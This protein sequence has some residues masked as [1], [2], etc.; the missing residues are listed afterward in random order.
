MAKAVLTILLT[1]AFGV[2]FYCVGY[3]IYAMVT[4]PGD[5]VKKD[6]F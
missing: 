4:G 2:F 5:E 1:G 3:M 6:E